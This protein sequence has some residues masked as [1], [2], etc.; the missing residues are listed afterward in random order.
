MEFWEFCEVAFYKLNKAFGWKDG[1][2]S[3]LAR[4]EINRKLL[5]LRQDEMDAIIN[6]YLSY[7]QEQSLDALPAGQLRARWEIRKKY[8]EKEEHETDIKGFLRTVQFLKDIKE[9]K[10]SEGES[11]VIQ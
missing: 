5:Q 8:R 10:T 6:N 2:I 4:S 3:T 9:G 7:K 11:E 1:Y